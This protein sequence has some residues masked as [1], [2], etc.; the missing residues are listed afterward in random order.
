M[1]FE[2]ITL[3][4]C[5]TLFLVVGINAAIY[6][7]LYRGGAHEQIDILRHAADRIREP[8]KDEEDALA[9]LAKRV[10]ELKNNKNE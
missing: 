7:L 6:A 2:N 5:L 3:V 1:N 10:S 8:W 4:V 9:E